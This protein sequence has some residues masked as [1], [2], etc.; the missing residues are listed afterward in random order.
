MDGE[1]VERVARAIL[2]E[3]GYINNP[4]IAQDLAPESLET[5]SLYARRYARAA[6]EAL[7]TPTRDMVAAGREDGCADWFDSDGPLLAWEA[8]INAA[9]TQPVASEP[10]ATNYAL[11][12]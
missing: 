5:T 3:A 2:R 7:R 8:M 9:L 6:I 1:M 4:K 11:T 10:S 12:I